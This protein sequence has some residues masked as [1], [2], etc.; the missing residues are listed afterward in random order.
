MVALVGGRFMSGPGG[1]E[2][3]GEPVT[4]APRTLPGHRM[5]TVTVRNTG[6]D[7]LS[8]RAA[9]IELLDEAGQ[10]LRASTAFGRAR[11]ATVRRATISPGASLALDLVWRARPESGIPA[12]IVLGETEIDLAGEP[13]SSAR[14]AAAAGHGAA[15]S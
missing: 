3:D 10:S 4:F 6:P 13:P 2:L 9:E 1:I 11:A 8:L 7:V 15:R 14:A 12:R 5:L